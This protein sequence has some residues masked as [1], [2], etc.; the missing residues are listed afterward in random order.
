MRPQDDPDWRIFVPGRQ[1]TATR[2]PGPLSAKARSV[3]GSFLVSLVLF[4]VVLAFLSLD[5][6]EDGME[7]VTGAVIVAAVGVAGLALTRR[8]T[9]NTPSGTGFPCP[10]PG[11]RCQYAGQLLAQVGGHEGDESADDRGVEPVGLGVADGVAADGSGQGG[12]GLA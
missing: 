3:F 11:I 2:E 6:I 12:S 9:R 10:D 4:G 8:G 1:Q 5:E 7:P